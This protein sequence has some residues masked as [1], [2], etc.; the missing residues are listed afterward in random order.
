MKIIEKSGGKLIWGSSFSAIWIMK[1]GNGI[2]PV[3]LSNGLVE[4]CCVSVP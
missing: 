4:I 3:P 1:V 2:F